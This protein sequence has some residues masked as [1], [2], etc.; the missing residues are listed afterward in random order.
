MS[1]VVP[2]WML[3]LVVIVGLVATP[4]AAQ[5]TESDARPSQTQGLSEE[6]AAGLTQAIN[7]LEDSVE[8][9]TSLEQPAREVILADLRAAV[10]SPRQWE[11]ARNETTAFTEALRSAPERLESFRAELAV[12]PQP[13][14][15]DVP[16]KMSLDP[17]REAVRAANAELEAA[18]GELQRLQAEAA[19]RLTHLDE[20]PRQLPELRARLSELN[21]ELQD[22]ATG[23]TP[24]QQARRLRRQAERHSIDAQ[25]RRLEAESASYRARQELLPVRRDL[26]QRRV[27]ES[28]DVAGPW[29][30]AEANLLRQEAAAGEREA[31]RQQ[32]EAALLAEPL[33]LV[34]EETAEFAVRRTGTTGIV[35][36]LS[37]VRDR[38]S[39]VRQ[40]GAACSWQ[41]QRLTLSISRRAIR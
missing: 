3:W 2:R 1:T 20:I 19:K 7:D 12:P 14:K 41:R 15:I 36:R 30:A 31:L 39:A 11:E 40:L 6:Q 35:E 22:Q 33:K 21:K 27:D 4:V 37:Q 13:Q 18:R 23:L 26:V 24:G 28:A 9:D 8:A 16:A 38:L 34:A 5:S 32:K 25:I 29:Q 10:E 17:V